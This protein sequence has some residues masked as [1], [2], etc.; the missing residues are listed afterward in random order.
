MTEL[1]KDRIALTTSALGT[2][3]SIICSYRTDKNTILLV[4]STSASG[5]SRSAHTHTP[6]SASVMQCILRSGNGI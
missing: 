5:L 2:D 6:L 3:L 4:G 1:T